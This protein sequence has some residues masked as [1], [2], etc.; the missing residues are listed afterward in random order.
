MYYGYIV[1]ITEETD[2]WDGDCFCKGPMFG[3]LDKK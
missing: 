2:V 1:H 3:H